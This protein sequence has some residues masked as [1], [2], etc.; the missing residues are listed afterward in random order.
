ML[1]EFVELTARIIEYQI[2]NKLA[3]PNK[4]LIKCIIPLINEQTEQVDMDTLITIA[5]DEVSRIEEAN[6][7]AE[8]TKDAIAVNYLLTINTTRNHSIVKKLLSW[9]S[10][11][12]ERRK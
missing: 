9:E 12:V 6:H 10:R 8:N 1:S 4:S 3:I 7:K 11:N 2:S 5:L